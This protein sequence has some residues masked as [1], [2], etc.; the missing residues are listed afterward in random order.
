MIPESNHKYRPDFPLDNGIIIET[1]GLFT[2]EDRKKMKLVKEQHPHLDIRLVFSN[3][4]A[5]I[6][7]KSK[8]TYAKWAEDNGFLWAHRAIPP[9]WL[10]LLKGA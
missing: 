2:T 6:A 7:K 1:K 9:G 8:T 10:T 4:M 3:A 5:R